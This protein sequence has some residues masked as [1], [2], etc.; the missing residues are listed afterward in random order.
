MSEK[1]MR[2]TGYKEVRRTL[3]TIHY[4]YQSQRPDLYEHIGDLAQDQDQT[5]RQNKRSKRKHSKKT[6]T[7]EAK[8]DKME[9]ILS[10]GDTET[11]DTE[12]TG[13]TGYK[14]TDAIRKPTEVI[15]DKSVGEKGGDK[16]ENR[17]VGV[18]SMKT[19]RV[20][21]VSADKKKADLVL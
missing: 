13:D 16:K 17:Q 4:Q 6:I 18:H 9:A 11:E 7:I 2:M 15:S 3:G 21:N 14:K 10:P 20:T 19:I 12:D 5:Y 8:R 1:G